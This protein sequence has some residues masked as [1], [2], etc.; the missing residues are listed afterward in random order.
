MMTCRTDS[1]GNPARRAFCP[2][3]RRREVAANMPVGGAGFLPRLR[4][5]PL[6]AVTGGLKLLRN[7]RRAADA[8]RGEG[9]DLPIQHGRARE[10]WRRGNLLAAQCCLSR[11]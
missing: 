1:A 10:P 7:L 8:A 11:P 3:E 2:S 9:G 5:I 6:S 4:V